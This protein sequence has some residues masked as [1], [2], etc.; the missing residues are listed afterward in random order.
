[1]RKLAILTGGLIGSTY[2]YDHITES[3]I[4]TRNL[5]TIKC[6]LN[7]LYSYKIAFNE[8]NCMQIHENIAK[9]IYESKFIM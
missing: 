4:F 1:M 6:G 9:D 3:F 8:D 2:A 7:I 5:R